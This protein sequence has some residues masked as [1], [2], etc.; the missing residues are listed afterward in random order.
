MKKHIQTMTCAAMIC[1]CLLGC[2]K[3]ESGRPATSPDVRETTTASYVTDM[4]DITNVGETAAPGTQHVTQELC[5]N[6]SIDAEAVIPG[7]NQYS[8][9][10]LKMVD[11]DPDR[12]FNLFCPGGYGSYTMEDRDYYTV[13]DESS[14]K[15]LVVYE[16]SIYY[17]T[18][19]FNME[20][21][22]MQDVGTLMFYHSQDYPQA[23]PHDLSFMNVEDMEIF[24]KNILNQLGISWEPKLLR[25]VTLSGQE[26]LDF[27]KEL[28]GNS[29]NTGFRTPTTLTEATDTCYL[30]FNFSYDG[31]PL[32]GFEE[33]TVSNYEN[34]EPSPA[35]TATIMFN[36]DGIQTCTVFF[37]CTI[38]TASNPQP[39][40]NLEEAIALF[41]DKYDLQIL[42]D[43]RKFTDIWMEYIPV[44]R[45]QDL[46]LTPYWCFL[47]VDEEAKDSPNYFGS[48]DRFNSITGKDL[49]YG[50]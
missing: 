10:T 49:T 33:P 30:Q 21:R 15:E 2:G 23:A 28:F 19:N 1:V 48:A 8:T 34:W 22:P 7:K 5:E 16:N 50:G 18:Y 25:C 12:L 20:E 38:E 43:S 45:D 32:I 9:Y 24:G 35:V 47:E 46:V 37:P 6:L 17:S 42:F 40:L 13:Y 11:C 26:I 29:S 41:K 4:T 14:G 39:I 36:A 31:I 44:K 3:H 27:Q